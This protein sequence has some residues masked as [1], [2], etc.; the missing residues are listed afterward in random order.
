MGLP[1]QRQGRRGARGKTHRSVDLEG[2]PSMEEGPLK[3]ALSPRL[4]GQGQSF[5][6][7]R[8][9]VSTPQAP[10]TGGQAFAGLWGQSGQPG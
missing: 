9:Q 10:G 3:P 1:V 8:A 4:Q 5:L 6:G 2:A 7:T